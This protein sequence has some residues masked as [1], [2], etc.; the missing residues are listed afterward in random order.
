MA[1][2]RTNR[3]KLQV[4]SSGIHSSGFVQASCEDTVEGR[5]GTCI[6]AAAA[7]G[8]GSAAAMDSAIAVEELGMVVAGSDYCAAARRR[9]SAFSLETL[10]SQVYLELRFSSLP[11]LLGSIPGLLIH[12][13]R[14]HCG[15]FFLDLPQK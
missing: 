10:S 11:L 5:E 15:R 7:L 3:Q 13:H 6:E 4:G 1:A 8:M 14:G 9:D 12:S 2:A